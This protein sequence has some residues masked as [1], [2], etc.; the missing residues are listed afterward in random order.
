[1][2]GNFFDSDSSSSSES[3]TFDSEPLHRREEEAHS[4]PADADG[5]AWGTHGGVIIFL[6]FIFG[7]FFFGFCKD[8]DANTITLCKLQVGKMC[9]SARSSTTIF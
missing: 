6:I 3:S 4:S 2:G 8:T 5:L 7:V 1:M 9:C